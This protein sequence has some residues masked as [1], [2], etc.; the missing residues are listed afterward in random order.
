MRE[1]GKTLANE[2][3][4]AVRQVDREFLWGCLVVEGMVKDEERET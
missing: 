2:F 4:E 1:L 3:K